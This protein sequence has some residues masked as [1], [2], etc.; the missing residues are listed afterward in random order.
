MGR[1]E[2]GGRHGDDTPGRPGRA[3]DGSRCSRSA[4]G[5]VHAERAAVPIAS[6]VGWPLLHGPSTAVSPPLPRAVPVPCRRVMSRCV[7]PAG[8]GCDRDATLARHVSTFVSRPQAFPQ[9]C[10]IRPP[11]ATLRGRIR[12]RSA[13]HTNAEC[14][15]Q[16]VAWS[17]VRRKGERQEPFSTAL[18]TGVGIWGRRSGDAESGAV[19]VD[20]GRREERAAGRGGAVARW[21]GEVLQDREV[22]LIRFVSSVTW[23]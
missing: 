5:C 18:S 16:D 4:G 23:L 13:W 22:C 10:T 8:A 19:W 14:S 12:D 17:G 15:A 11:P 2:P 1:L 7:A 9:L 3:V 21:A 6:P 20:T